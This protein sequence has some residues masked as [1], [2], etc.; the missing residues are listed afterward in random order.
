MSTRNTPVSTRSTLLLQRQ[1][2]RR[3]SSL[4]HDERDD[5]NAKVFL[6]SFCLILIIIISNRGQQKR[7]SPFAQ[8]VP[9]VG[10]TGDDRS[11]ILTHA[12][13]RRPLPLSPHRGALSTQRGTLSTPRGTLSTHRGTLSTHRGTLCTHRGTLSTQRVLPA[14]GV[15]SPLVGVEWSIS[16]LAFW[17]STT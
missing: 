17:Q 11:E 4:Y 14:V 5:V 15:E 8:V 16:R 9:R 6:S 3:S 7:H 2:T 13:H 10:R 12:D 1:A